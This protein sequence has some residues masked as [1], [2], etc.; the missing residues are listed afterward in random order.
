MKLPVNSIFSRASTATYV[1]SA[2]IIQTAVVNEPRFNYD[3]A[4]NEFLGLL[5]DEGHTTF[6]DTAK[7]FLIVFGNH[8]P[9]KIL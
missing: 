2:G 6:T 3:P 8:L 4:T 1:N 9:V 7:I 5:L